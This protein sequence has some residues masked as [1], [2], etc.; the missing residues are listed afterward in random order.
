M[1]KY[2]QEPRLD[3]RRIAGKDVCIVCR[4]LARASPDRAPCSINVKVHQPLI[5]F[6][7]LPPDYHPF[8]ILRK[9]DIRAI[10]KQPPMQTNTSRH[11]ALH[12]CCLT[13]K[14]PKLKSNN[15]K[16]IRLLLFF[17]QSPPDCW[18]WPWS[19][20]NDTRTT[21]SSRF[22]AKVFDENFDWGWKYDRRHSYSSFENLI[23]WKHEYK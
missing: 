2:F 4:S 1:I 13:D 14:Y 6:L 23:Q 11:E 21:S 5:D 8:S 18:R 22:K 15:S 9:V 19:A 12:C 7:Q 17:L 3:K 20:W 10:T 16:F